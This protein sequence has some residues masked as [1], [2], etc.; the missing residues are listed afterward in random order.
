[1]AYLDRQVVQ[2]DETGWGHPQLSKQEASSGKEFL[3][4][5]EQKD[6]K[7]INVNGKCDEDALFAFKQLSSPNGHLYP[8]SKRIALKALKLWTDDPPKKLTWPQYKLMATTTFVTPNYCSGWAW[9][10][11]GI[12]FHVTALRKFLNLPPLPGH[13]ERK[14]TK[15]QRGCGRKRRKRRATYRSETVTKKARYSPSKSLITTMSEPSASS[16]SEGSDDVS[17]EILE[18]QVEI[19]DEPLNSDGNSS[20][21]SSDHRNNDDARNNGGAG[22]VNPGNLCYLNALV[23]CVNPIFSPYAEHM[24]NHARSGTIHEFGSLL[25]SMRSSDTALDASGLHSELNNT[26]NGRLP[27]GFQQDAHETWYA[28]Y[29]Q[30]MKNNRRACCSPGGVIMGDYVTV[31]TLSI[32]QCVDCGHSIYDHRDVKRLTSENRESSLLLTLPTNNKVTV[33]ISDLLVDTYDNEHDGIEL[34]EFKCLDDPPCVGNTRRRRRNRSKKTRKKSAEGKKADRIVG[35]SPSA[36]VVTLKRHVFR[37]DRAMKNTV[38]V[39]LKQHEVFKVFSLKPEEDAVLQRRQLLAVLCHI[40]RNMTSGHYYT[41]VSDVLG[42]WKKYDDDTVTD[43]SWADVIKENS[44]AYML[45]Y[46]FAYTIQDRDRACRSK[47]S[48]CTSK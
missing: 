14:L 48:R 5:L 43:S 1:M 11:K 18:E 37:A 7:I 20:D 21:E 33:S 16:S 34:E 17:T 38:R 44:S 30:L 3:I 2:E 45:L 27:F 46:G 25:M 35:T 12:C 8:L 10:N 13:S 19:P 23:Q 26:A 24:A 39:Q 40:G 4:D 22:L 47:R 36:L 15:T 9:G 31:E 28:L 29:Q 42:N 32:Y 41:Y 6:S